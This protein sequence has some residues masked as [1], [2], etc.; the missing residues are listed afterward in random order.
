MQ[1]IRGCITDLNT[2]AAQQA[3][4]DCL[5][6]ELRTLLVLSTHRIEKARNIASK[7]LNRLIKSFPSL[8]C[9]PPLVFTI[10]DV[11][12]LLRRSCENEFTDEVRVNLE[13]V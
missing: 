8:M 7:F 9:D 4:P 5:S 1:V 6:S 11:L 2:K 3:L 12:T 10:L 13:N